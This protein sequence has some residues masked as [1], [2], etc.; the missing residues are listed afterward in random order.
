MPIGS[1]R[2]VMQAATDFV[3]GGSDPGA[4]NAATAPAAGD[5]GWYHRGPNRRPYGCGRVR[6]H[7]TTGGYDRKV[8][9]NHG[10]I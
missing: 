4:A 8:S 7:L 10:W 2:M 6:Y 1:G 5:Q 3:V 9:P